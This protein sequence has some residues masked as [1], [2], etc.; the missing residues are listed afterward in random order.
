MC[1]LVFHVTH[2]LLNNTYHIY[3][4]HILPPTR[5]LSPNDSNQVWRYG[6]MADKTAYDESL[7]GDRTRGKR[8]EAVTSKD[9]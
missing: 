6:G 8:D 9:R 1:D 3:L 4:T 2:L 5:Q 7:W